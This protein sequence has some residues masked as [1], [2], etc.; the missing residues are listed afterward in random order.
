[1]P[2]TTKP[3][4]PWLN[5]KVPSP[6]PVIKASTKAVNVALKSIKAVDAV[7]SLPAQLAVKVGKGGL[8]LADKA[9]AAANAVSLGTNAKVA[10]VAKSAAS[11]ITKPVAGAATKAVSKIAATTTAKIATRAIPIVGQVLLGI[12]ALGTAIQA[13]AP[14][15]YK[16]FN[17]GVREGGS[18]IGIPDWLTEGALDFVGFGEQSTGQQLVGLAETLAAPVTGGRNNS[19]RR[20]AFGGMISEEVRGF[21]KSGRRYVFGEGGSEMVTPMSKMGRRS[22]GGD[23]GVT[24]NV[25]VNGNIYSD[26]DMLKFQRTIMKA[27]ETSSTRKAKL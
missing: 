21:G 16:S 13:I 1:M 12:D 22:G 20:H 11:P 5:T 18:A 23:S 6:A 10:N 9:I 2:K 15:H 8:K 25:T 24:V 7:M 27:I 19:G 3:R 14:D 26:R 17:K 4:T